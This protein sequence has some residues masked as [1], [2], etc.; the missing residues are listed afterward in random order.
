MADQI[1]RH[2]R[3]DIETKINLEFEKFSGFLQE[4]FVLFLIRSPLG[5]VFPEDQN[6]DEC[7][8]GQTC[9]GEEALELIHIRTVISSVPCTWIF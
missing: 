2:P 8:K 4:Y 9:S 1:Q 7:C 5:T 6:N 3:A